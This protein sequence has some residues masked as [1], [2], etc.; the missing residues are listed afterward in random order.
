MIDF[1]VGKYYIQTEGS[2]KRKVFFCR[3]VSG[4]PNMDKKTWFGFATDVDKPDSW[5]PWFILEGDH[6]HS[7]GWA[8]AQWNKEK[9]TWEKK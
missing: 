2:V 7:R 3:A 9:Q 4:T 5:L 6:I 1:K 8:E